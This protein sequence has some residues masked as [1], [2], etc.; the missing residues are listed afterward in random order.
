MSNLVPKRKDGSN[1]EAIELYLQSDEG[2][3]QLTDKQKLLL[4][5]WTYADELIREGEIRSR[6]VVAKMIIKKF[7]VSRATAFQ[8]IVN[9][10]QVFSSSTPLNKRYRIGLR[11]EFLEKQIDDLYEKQE[12]IAAAMLEKTLQ[13][14]YE[15]YPD[16][17]PARSPKKIIFKVYAGDMPQ[18]PLAVDEARKKAQEKIIELKRRTDGSFGTD[19][20]S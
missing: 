8:D 7:D 16:I 2:A 15:T 13:K 6:E 19:T 11:I 10:E 17:K 14:Y 9:A 4:Q 1:R 3:I 5:R 18:A 12:Y 20:G